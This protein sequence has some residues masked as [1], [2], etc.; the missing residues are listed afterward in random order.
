MVRISR[1]D[2]RSINKIFRSS[3]MDKFNRARE[4][5]I[6]L[7]LADAHPKAIIINTEKE[8]PFFSLAG[9]THELFYLAGHRLIRIGQNQYLD[10]TIVVYSAI[11]TSRGIDFIKNDGGI[12]AILD[13]ITV[14]I[15]NESIKAL[16]AAQI[17]SSDLNQTYKQKLLSLLRQL[18]ADST[19]L[20]TMNLVSSAVSNLPE[21]LQILQNFVGL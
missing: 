5:E 6:L 13:T 11:I 1:Y 16:I 9:Y 17:E 15:D 2:A 20:L 4:R 19:K 18:P 3:Y 21:L 14:K 10:G 7:R 12:S 8:K